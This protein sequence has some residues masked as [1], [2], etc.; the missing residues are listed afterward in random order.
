MIADCCLA[1]ADFEPY[2]GG[3]FM[4][5]VEDADAMFVMV[6]MAQFNLGFFI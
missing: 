1:I 2:A 5:I 3:L 4:Y 6:Y